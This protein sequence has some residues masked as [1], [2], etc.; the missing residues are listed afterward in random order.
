VI[1]LKTWVQQLI[2]RVAV[3]GAVQE[4]AARFRI[5]VQVLVSP[6]FLPRYALTLLKTGTTLMAFSLTVIGMVMVSIDALILETCTNTLAKLPTKHAVYA[7]GETMILHPRHPQRSQ[8]RGLLMSLL[9]D[10]QTFLLISLLRDPQTCLLTSLLGDPQTCLLTSLLGDPQ[11]CLLMSLLGDPQT[12]L[13]MSLLGDPQ[14][15]LLMSLL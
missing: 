7:V 9:G 8:A 15:Y 11:T 2:K 10:P 14:T 4:T 5:Q 1:V 12:C 6:R 13:L 3:A